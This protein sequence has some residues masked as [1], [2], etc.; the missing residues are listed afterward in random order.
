MTPAVARSPAVASG[1]QRSKG[2]AGNRRSPAVASG[3]QLV[4]SCRSPVSRQS[5]ASGRQPVASGCQVASQGSSGSCLGTHLR[6]PPQRCSAPRPTFPTLLLT[7]SALDALAQA[8]QGQGLPVSHQRRR[9]R[10]SSSGRSAGAST[11]P[12]A[13]RSRSSAGPSTA[14][15][16]RLKGGL[17][18]GT[19]RRIEPGST[20]VPDARH[21]HALPRA[22]A[23]LH[24]RMS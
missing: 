19:W 4:A 13:R 6:T 8:D 3:R 9:P 15:A 11:C 22:I 20:R 1:R 14:V 7:P 2:G 10:R 21:A 5:V 16:R 24:A 23:R 12:S 18:A 17:T